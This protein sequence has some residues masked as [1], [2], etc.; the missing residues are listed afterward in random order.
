MTIPKIGGCTLN[1]LK[2]ELNLKTAAV[3]AIPTALAI[4][5][6]VGGVM[7]IL[8][9]QGIN[10]GALNVIGEVGMIGGGVLAG[11]GGVFLLATLAWIVAKV[12]QRYRQDTAKKQSNANLAVPEEPTVKT[13]FDFDISHL[14]TLFPKEGSKDVAG[15]TRFKHASSEGTT[16]V[17]AHFTEKATL[18]D[19]VHYIAYSLDTPPSDEI[20]LIHSDTVLTK[21][22]KWQEQKWID[23]VNTR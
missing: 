8:V 1:P 6:A 21:Q 7:A 19:V 16:E 3:A 9:S 18:L 13:K 2:Y 11:V 17:V 4:I 14:Q 23:V 12:I 5:V 20:N 22:D 15:K 10:I